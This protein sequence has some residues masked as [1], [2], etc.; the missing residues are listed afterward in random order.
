[1]GLSAVQEQVKALKGT[2]GLTSE[3]HQGTM[4][5][6]RLPLTLSI[7]KLLVFSVDSHYMAISVDS[8]A[9]I[10]TVPDADIQTIQGRQ[11]Y[12]Y[13]DQLIPLYPTSSFA[14]HYPLPRRLT[15][16]L[17]P[18]PLPLQA[19]TPLLLI[20]DGDSVIA[21]E[22]DQILNEQELVI[23]PFGSVVNSPAYL[24][25]CTILGDG[26]LIPVIDGSVLVSQWKDPMSREFSPTPTLPKARS[27]SALESPTIL[28]IDDSLTT[29]QN[30]TLTL[31]KAG[32]QVIQ[33]GHGQEAL[34]KFAAGTGDS[35]YFL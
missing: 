22:V 8:L 10:V 7:A 14:H 32:Y 1:M 35:S 26:T 4:F 23:K 30:L 2:I 6:I 24:Y 21:L 9:A 27:T 20:A 19:K 12:H 11:F 29:R 25:G 28:V 13:D 16:H 33:A 3:V 17:P 15:G 5:T 31:H 18:I 34:E